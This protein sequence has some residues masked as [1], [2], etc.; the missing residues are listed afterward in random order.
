MRRVRGGEEVVGE[1]GVP[2]DGRGASGR[3]DGLKGKQPNVQILAE[4]GENV[5][6]DEGM[7]VDEG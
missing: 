5:L 6:V 7:E 1:N 4:A 2:Q 3:K